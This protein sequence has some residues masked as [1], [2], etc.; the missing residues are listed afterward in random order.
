MSAIA[1][2]GICGTAH[3]AV[4]FTSS[5]DTYIHSG[6][7]S[8]NYG[9]DTYM[10]S[11]QTSAHTRMAVFS[12]DL[13]GVTPGS[14]TSATLQ[15]EDVIGGTNRDYQVYGLIETTESF[16]ETT[17]T[18]NDAAFV[19]GAS[20]DLNQVYGGAALGTYS[21]AQNAVNTVFDVTS[22]NYL[23]FLNASTDSIVTFVIVDTTINTTGSGWATKEH[24]TA[25]TPTLTIVSIPEPSSLALLALS[26]LA[27]ISRRRK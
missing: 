17:L 19:S 22:G 20:I 13:S 23:D 2:L 25:L 16:D 11:N 24:T 12:F 9:A 3:A 21:N 8:T 7:A 6:N 10:V 5:A 14:I 1:A 15:L 18:W 26:G 4:S 27:L